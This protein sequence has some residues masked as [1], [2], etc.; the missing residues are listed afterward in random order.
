M[1][2]AGT[3]QGQGGRRQNEVSEI[4]DRLADGH[5]GD[6]LQ[7]GQSDALKEEAVVSRHK[8]A[9]RAGP[10]RAGPGGRGLPPQHRGRGRELGAGTRCGPGAAGGIPAA[11]CCEAGAS[12]AVRASRPQP[13]AR[14]PAP[15]RGPGGRAGP[16]FGPGGR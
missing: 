13:P 10:G 7:Q 9:L 8:A 15:R 16:G 14:C 4:P 12:G 2:A 6:R 1:A 3:R 5:R 11:P